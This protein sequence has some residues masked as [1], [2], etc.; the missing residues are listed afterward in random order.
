M[1]KTLMM[2]KAESKLALSGKVISNTPE[3]VFNILL[4]LEDE[5]S[6]DHKAF[7]ENVVQP[8]I[9]RPHLGQI[10]GFQKDFGAFHEIFRRMLLRRD[11]NMTI[12]D[13]SIVS[14][15]SKT[16]KTHLAKFSEFVSWPLEWRERLYI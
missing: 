7:K 15:K 14:L 2:L 5:S 12:D 16:V 9:E 11:K 1:V 3:D 6:K 13:A 10:G 4:F 8:I